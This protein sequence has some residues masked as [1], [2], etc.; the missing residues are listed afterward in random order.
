[1]SH[2][3]FSPKSSEFY[4]EISVGVEADAA[5]SVYYVTGELGRVH[6]PWWGCDLG[7]WPGAWSSLP[8]D[9]PP[10]WG[11]SLLTQVSSFHA[12]L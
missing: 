8:Q 5:A 10:L 4:V 6:G 1:M 3:F 11:T 9:G 2:I 7:E 12:Y